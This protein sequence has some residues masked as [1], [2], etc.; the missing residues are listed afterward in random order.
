MFRI[1]KSKKIWLAQLDDFWT[2]DTTGRRFDPGLCKAHEDR[3]LCAGYK[4]VRGW[5][6]A[7]ASAPAFTLGMMDGPETTMLSSGGS[8][9]PII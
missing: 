9:P 7:G 1:T 4:F 8:T 2:F 5:R 3:G 6:S